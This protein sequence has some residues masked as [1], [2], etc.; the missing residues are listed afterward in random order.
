M[1]DSCL[2]TFCAELDSPSA[3]MRH[4][5]TAN[6]GAS[7]GMALGHHMATGEV[8]LVCLC[9]GGGPNTFTTLL[10]QLRMQNMVLLLAESGG[11]AGAITKFIEAYREGFPQ[12]DATEPQ[13]I[14]LVDKLADINEQ[15]REKIKSQ[16]LPDKTGKV[17]TVAR[18]L[19]DAATATPQR[20]HFH[21]QE[22]G[23]FDEVRLRV[24]G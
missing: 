5:I 8:P 24:S 10:E 19:V 9:V 6:E 20:I 23:P 1:P 14:A 2:A 13:L 16:A 18:V 3:G 12:E 7:V 15:E 22:D 21:K 4:V 11:A 17:K